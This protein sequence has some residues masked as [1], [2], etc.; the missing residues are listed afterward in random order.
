MGDRVK[1]GR[2][3]VGR[4]RRIESGGVMAGGAGALHSDSCRGGG[5]GGG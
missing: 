1:E 5:G 2:D 4:S 3:G